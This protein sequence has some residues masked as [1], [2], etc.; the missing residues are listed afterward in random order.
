MKNYKVVKCEQCG[1]EFT[2]FVT[3]RFCDECKRLRNIECVKRRKAQIP[4]EE[5]RAA[6]LRYYMTH[7]EV[8]LAG[9]RR[10]L[11]AH[12]NYARDWYR[13]KKEAQKCL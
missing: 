13:R 5:R 11:A 10:W 4:A 7:K 1:V 8:I 12:P 9:R 6:N 2:G 3:R